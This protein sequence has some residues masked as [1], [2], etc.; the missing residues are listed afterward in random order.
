MPFVLACK[1]SELGPEEPFQLV[2]DDHDPIAVIAAEDGVYAVDDTCTH[3][4][5]S[6]CEGYVE[7]HEIICTLHMARFCI[8][9]GEVRMPPAYE[10]LRTYEVKLDGDEI[11]VNTEP[12][13]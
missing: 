2:G 4:D 1:R 10:D 9:T 8:R 6:L 7:G 13:D 12:R 11:W 3:A 5:W